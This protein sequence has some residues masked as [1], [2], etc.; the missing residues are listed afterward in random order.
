MRKNSRRRAGVACFA[1]VG[2]Y[3]VTWGILGTCRKMTP[4]PEQYPGPKIYQT[5]LPNG[6]TP[7]DMHEMAQQKF[8]RERAL[9]RKSEGLK[10]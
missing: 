4:K 10:P 7:A 6:M 8:M 1:A 2:L 5:R 3:C 9:R